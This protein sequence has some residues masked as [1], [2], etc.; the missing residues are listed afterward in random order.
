MRGPEPAGGMSH[1][2][3]Q[4]N[5]EK[6]P[7]QSPS[8]SE[9]HQ[10][11]AE[12]PDQRAGFIVPPD[13]TWRQVRGCLHAGE[14]TPFACMIHRDVTNSQVFQPWQEKATGGST[15]RAPTGPGLPSGRGQ[16]RVSS[17]SSLQVP[18]VT[19]PGS[20]AQLAGRIVFPPLQVFQQ[21]VRRE[22]IC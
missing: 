5:P 3:P 14:F 8:K 1:L 18:N 4:T 16:S 17:P 9:K 7:Q 13:D 10:W 12:C 22:N 21:L 19:W 20:A 6:S 11:W 15:E 2:H